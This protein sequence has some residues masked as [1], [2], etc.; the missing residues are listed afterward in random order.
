M[1]TGGKI[2]LGC[3]CLALVGLLA[4]AGACG[5]LGYWVKGKAAG[6]ASDFD[7][8]T[9]RATAVTDEIE[10]WEK[11]ANENPYTA[12]A[13][14]LI[15]EPRLLKFLEVR[16]E[17][18]AVYEAHKADLDALQKKSQ[19]PSDK[20]SP[21]DLW[22]AGGQLAET[23]GALKLAQAK[24]LAEVGMSEAEYRDIQIAVYKSAWASET[25]RKT[26]RMPAE[27]LEKSMAEAGRQVEDAMS[28]G[29][30]EAQKQKVPGAGQLSPEDAKKL[31]AELAEAGKA[32]K[33]L[34][35]PKANLELFRKHEAEIRAYAMSGLGFIGL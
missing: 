25:E 8:M 22:N 21:R 3:G 29:V 20:L 19:T 27:A 18:H 32:A 26:G 23:L 9:K 15:A 6:V 24:A 35:V 12:P 4:A 1:S 11:K 16:K 30:A 10:R 17:V 5:L 7:A 2:A 13:D 14:A 31:G 33:A 34:E 28:R